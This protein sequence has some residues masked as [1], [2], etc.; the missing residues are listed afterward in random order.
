MNKLLKVLFT[1]SII[2]LLAN[3]V[4]DSTSN[5][6]NKIKKDITIWALAEDVDFN[7]QLIDNLVIHNIECKNS[8]ICEELNFILKEQFLIRYSRGNVYSSGNESVGSENIFSLKG[9]ISVGNRIFPAVLYYK[10][11]ENNTFYGNL[12]FKL[13]TVNDQIVIGIKGRQ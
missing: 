9:T 2:V 7:E 11:F 4:G 5:D 3:C 1:T 13:P 10:L 12:S 6:A 8:E